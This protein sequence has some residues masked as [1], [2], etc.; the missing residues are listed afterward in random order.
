MICPRCQ[1]ANPDEHRY[2][3]QCGAR[4]LVREGP[5]GGSLREQLQRGLALLVE[6]EWSLGRS[7][8][9]RCLALDLKHG[10]SLLY[11]GLIECL[12]GAPR[13]ARERLER[14]VH[15]DPEL[16]NA[17]LLLGLMAESEEDFA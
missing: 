16:V 3:A 15:L 11:L 8:L 7:Q 17:W 10:A 5:L 14:A 9:E 12:E 1:S 6:G 4:L 13:R 2:C